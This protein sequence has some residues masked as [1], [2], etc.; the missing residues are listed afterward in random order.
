MD[1]FWAMNGIRDAYILEAVP[2]NWK[3]YENKRQ[4]KIY[5]SFF[6]LGLTA[7]AMLIVILCVNISYPAFARNIPFIGGIFGYLQDNLDFSGNFVEYANS[8]GEQVKSNGITAT[9][10]EIYCDEKNLFVAYRI[11]SDKPFDHYGKDYIKTNMEYHSMAAI[12][13]HPEIKLSDVGVGGLQGE[14]VDEFTFVGVEFYSLYEDSFPDSF[15][16]HIVI[17]SWNLILNDAS[18]KPIYGSWRFQIPVQVNYEDI[19]TRELNIV[20]QEHSIDKVVISPVMITV[21]TSYPD[22]YRDTPDYDVMAFGDLSDVDITVQGKFDYDI[23]KGYVRISRD[24]VKKTLELYVIDSSLLPEDVENPYDKE[25]IK[26]Y[27][28]VSAKIDLQ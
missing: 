10:S 11:E 14:F 28:I 2:Q 26:Q 6:K 20:N 18:E 5:K 1:L 19:E 27:A 25:I 8:V 7:A 21:Y 15:T 23:G 17:S 3:Y 13:N 22:I 16:F 24:S 4:K 9:I 12:E